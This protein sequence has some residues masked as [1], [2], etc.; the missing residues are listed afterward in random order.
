M[1]QRNSQC[2]NKFLFYDIGNI[3]LE[4]LHRLLTI[5]YEGQISMLSNRQKVTFGI[6]NV[7]T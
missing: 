1:V 4:A 2:E 7:V 3:P 6:L 5:F